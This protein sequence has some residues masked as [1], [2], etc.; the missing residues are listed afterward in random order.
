[1]PKAGLDDAEPDLSGCSDI[2][3]FRRCASSV[4]TG[5]SFLLLCSGCK[6]SHYQ[7]LFDTCV[8]N[9]WRWTSGSLIPCLIPKHP[10]LHL[11][12]ATTCCPI[13]QTQAGTSSASPWVV[14]GGPKEQ[15]P[16]AHSCVAEF[17]YCFHKGT[18][19]KIPL[20]PPTGRI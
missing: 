2:S 17:C 18:G 6:S 12:W 13:L 14:L 1:M 9:V 10:G 4:Y 8:S 7:K 15:T 11:L 19:H 20:L 5:S 3:E 16:H